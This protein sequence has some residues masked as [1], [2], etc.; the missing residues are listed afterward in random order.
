MFCAG[1]F[2]KL[3]LVKKEYERLDSSGAID[4]AITLTTNLRN[5]LTSGIANIIIDIIPGNL[6]ADARNAIV[7]ALDASIKE[8]DLIKGC[9]TLPNIQD[10]ITCLITKLS[11]MGTVTQ[12]ALIVKLLSLLIKGLD[13]AQ[14]K[15]HYYDTIAQTAV[16][17]K[18]K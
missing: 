5:A 3:K 15:Q 18:L 6:D 2:N 10:K 12:D 8:L 17:V 1:V 13:D 9:S 7:N 11:G 4:K 14:L 16:N